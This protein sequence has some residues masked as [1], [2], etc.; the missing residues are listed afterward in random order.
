MLESLEANRKLNHTKRY[1]RICAD[2]G[3]FVGAFVPFGVVMLAVRLEDVLINVHQSV[4][5]Y[6]TSGS[7]RVD[8]ES[9]DGFAFY[10]GK[11][12]KSFVVVDVF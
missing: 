10:R 2:A 8:E 9:M 4:C 6:Q 7:A 12:V 11:R 5:S 1:L 3:E